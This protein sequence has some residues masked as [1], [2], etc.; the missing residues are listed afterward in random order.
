MATAGIW[1]PWAEVLCAT[2]HGPKFGDKKQPEADFQK[3]CTEAVLVTDELGLCHCDKCK[4]PVAVRRDVAAYSRLRDAFR[5]RGGVTAS[6]RQT[7]GMCAA[8]AVC[9]E[10]TEAPLVFI[11]GF[12]DTD[13]YCAGKY[14]TEDDVYNGDSDSTALGE[15]ITETEIVEATRKALEIL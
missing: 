15:Y 8:L 9:R 3:R 1:T 12:D 6:L 11:A 10:N 14:L 5:A 13:S 4:A 2:C 7:G